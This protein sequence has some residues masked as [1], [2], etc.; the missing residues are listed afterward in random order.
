MAKHDVTKLS[1]NSSQNRK[2]SSSVKM[3]FCFVGDKADKCSNYLKHVIEMLVKLKSCVLPLR[4]SGRTRVSADTMRRHTAG[5][6]N[7]LN[8]SVTDSYCCTA[9][10]Q[11]ELRPCRNSNDSTEGR[12]NMT[13]KE[14]IIM[15]TEGEIIGKMW[16]TLN[17][18]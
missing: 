12:G 15:Q 2:C 17:T 7:Y 9:D 1:D 16:R 6:L 3:I 11:T 10:T 18:E 5:K 4:R 14:R 13:E 8:S